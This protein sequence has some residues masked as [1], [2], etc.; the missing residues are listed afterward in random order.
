MINTKTQDEETMA[1]KKDILLKTAHQ[2]L[3]D[4]IKSL[5]N[6]KA[7]FDEQ[8]KDLMHE[9]DALQRR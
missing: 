8:S 9:L 3:E 2:V 6:L 4:E 5:Q 7:L 1:S